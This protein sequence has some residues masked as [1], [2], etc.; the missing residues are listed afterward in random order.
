MIAKHLH[1]TIYS[2]FD[3]GASWF[4]QQGRSTLAEELATGSVSAEVFWHRW[5]REY[6]PQLQARQKWVNPSRSFAV[7]D[8]VLV[9]DERYPRSPWP[10]GRI[11]N[12]HKSLHD[13]LVR[14]IKVKTV[15][16]L[17]EL[18]PGA[19]YR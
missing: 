9:V 15:A 7:G 12:V 19:P 18:P 8:I 11:V 6:L 3:Q 4:I 2:S 13:G 14:S 5:I 16:L 10:L 17:L 1:R